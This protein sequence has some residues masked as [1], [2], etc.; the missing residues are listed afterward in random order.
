MQ[1]A[2]VLSKLTYMHVILVGMFSGGPRI[3]PI[4][5]ALKKYVWAFSTDGVAAKN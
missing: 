5:Y 3:N 4:L 1:T 2:W